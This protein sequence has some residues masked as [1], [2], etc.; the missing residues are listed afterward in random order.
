MLKLSLFW[1]RRDLRLYDNHGLF[2]AL[3]ENAQV[4]PLFI[5]DQNILKSLPKDDLRVQFIHQQVLRLKEELQSKGFDLW[6]YYGNPKDV[7]KKIIETD[8][9]QSVYANEDYEPQAIQRDQQVQLVLESQKIPLIKVKDQ[10]VFEKSEVLTDANRPYTVFTP[11]KRKW[12]SLLSAK[13]LESFDVG[14]Y[15]HHFHKPKKMQRALQLSELGFSPRIFDY[16][17]DELMMKTLKQYEKTR[18]FPALENGTSKMGLHLRFGTVSIR[19]MVREAIKTNETWLSELIWREFFMQILWHEPRVVSQSF[20][21]EYDKIAWRN[22]AKDFKKW[23]DGQTGYP[24]VDAGMREL[25]ETGY[26]HNRVRMV[27]ASFLTKHLLIHW[28]WGEKY[29]AEKL[30]DFDLSA[31]NGNWQWAAG[32]GCDAAP[33]FRIFNPESQLTKFD[34]DLVYVKKWV[35][36][37]GTSKYPEPMIEHNEARG[38]ALQEYSK[39]LKKK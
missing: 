27:T 9:I 17:L 18:D 8:S 6:I 7:F 33:Y 25:N 32:S 10:V 1:F 16:P 20:R 38:R 12:L 29:F 15:E 14:I 2:K 34:K 30:L 13:K 21:P 22:N 3:S 5:F 19:E 31:N 11:Y 35:P 26:M 36:E 23:C 39:V 37:Y 28:T 24:L 4:Q